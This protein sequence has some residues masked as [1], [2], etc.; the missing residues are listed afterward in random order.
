MA[1]TP[2]F[3]FDLIIGGGRVF[4][5]FSDSLLNAGAAGEQRTIEP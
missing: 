5:N 1:F 4:P 3:A 2:L